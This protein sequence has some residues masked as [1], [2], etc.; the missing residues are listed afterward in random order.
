MERMKA[1]D[2][3]QEV[4][5][6][7]DLYIHGHID[8]RGFLDRAQKYAVGGLTAAVMLEALRPNFALGQQVPKDDAR[9]RITTVEIPS[10]QGNGTIKAYVTRPKSATGKLPVVLVVHENRGLNPHIEDIARRV[11]L[12]NFLAI[13]PDGLTTVGG[14]PGA[15][16]PE[17]QRE[18]VAT[19]KFGTVPGM[20]MTEDFVAAA[21]F[22]KAHAEG[23]GKVGT[24][25]FCYG[26]GIVNTLAF[27]V[28]ELN[29]GVAYY[30]NQPTNPADIAK[31]KSPLLLQYGSLD[32]GITGRWPAYDAA[33]TAAGV[34]HTGYVYEGANHGFNNDTGA[35][36]DPNSAKLSWDRTM[37]FFEKY[38]R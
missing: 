29:C 18:T 33:L 20:K 17:A 8:R 7:F 22:A 16:T 34:V 31:I 28:P 23:T 2:F 26:G 3:P 11:G 24:V 13:A 30:G 5:N 25:G 14:Y 32:A 10:P 19:Q 12:A 38:L 36:Y 21:G 35:R 15:E 1:S 27:R 4:L 6:I 9:L 37:A